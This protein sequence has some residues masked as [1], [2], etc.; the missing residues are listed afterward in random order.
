ME[1]KIG[2]LEHLRDVGPDR[3]LVD[4]E[5]EAISMRRALEMGRVPR[6]V[7]M[8]G[9]GWT[10]GAPPGLEEAAHALWTEDWVGW[11]DRTCREL[12]PMSDERWRS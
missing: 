1:E 12:R 7:F 9:D 11:T 8:R 2:I 5:G 6:V 10:L 3:V 4:A